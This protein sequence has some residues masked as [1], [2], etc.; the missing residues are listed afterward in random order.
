MVTK[1][2]GSGDSNRFF[3]TVTKEE[4]R[5]KRNQILTME[6]AIGNIN[7]IY[8]MVTKEKYT[9]DTKRIMLEIARITITCTTTNV[10]QQTSNSHTSS[11]P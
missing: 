8:V 2:K 5:Q 3:V 9:G 6:K 7:L 1:E 10:T 11:I 4:H